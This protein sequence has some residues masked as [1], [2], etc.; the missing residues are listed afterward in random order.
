MGRQ[1]VDAALLLPGLGKRRLQKVLFGFLKLSE[2]QSRL[3]WISPLPVGAPATSPVLISTCRK[4]PF[5][6]RSRDFM[7]WKGPRGL[8]TQYVLPRPAASISPENLLEMQILRSC[9]RP[10]ESGTL[11]GGGGGG[12]CQWSGFQ[13]LHDSQA[14]SSLAITIRVLWNKEFGLYHWFSTG[15]AHQNQ[16]GSFKTIWIWRSHAQKFSFSWFEVGFWNLR[17]F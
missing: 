6:S 5:R 7:S 15:A 9:L 16:L 10:R 2:G 14:Y 11:G 4:S 1:E 12:A 13:A 8:L 17:N 3:C